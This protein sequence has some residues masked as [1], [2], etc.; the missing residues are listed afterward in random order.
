M[1]G[2]TDQPRVLGEPPLSEQEVQRL[3]DAP[4][5]TGVLDTDRGDLRWIKQRVGTDNAF[6]VAGYWQDV[7]LS[8]TAT[9][10]S[11]FLIFGLLFVLI[12]ALLCWVMA[13]HLVVSLRPSTAVTAGIP[14]NPEPDALVTGGISVRTRR[15]ATMPPG[16][17]PPVRSTPVPQHTMSGAHARPVVPPAARV[18]DEVI[19]RLIGEGFSARP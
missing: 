10:T 5:S 1:Q 12:S 13:G 11:T 8:I 6:F 4:Q 16:T 7:A 3:L 14:R 15:P 2:A 18:S 9:A 19:T 17:T